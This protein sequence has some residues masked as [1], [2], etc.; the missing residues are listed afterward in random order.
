M[1]RSRSLAR[2][3]SAVA[4]L[5][6]LLSL[7]GAASPAVAQHPYRILVTNDDGFR[8]PG[9]AALVTA[10]APLG[11]LTIV[12][13]AE[14][15]SGI[16]QA[17][18][19]F[20]PIYADT[21][22]VAGHPATS[23]AATPASCV[24]VALAKLM[25]QPPDLVVSG[26][27]RGSNFGL[28]AYISGTVGAAREAAIEGIPAIAA[29]LDNA[30]HPNYGPAAEATARIAAIV[31][32]GGLPRRVFLNVNVPAGPAERLKGIRFARQSTQMGTERYDEQHTPY[33]RRLFW[34]F[35][36]QPEGAEPGTDV[37]AALDGYVSVTPL[38][39][40]EFDEKDFDALGAR[41]R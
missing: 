11:E 35:F 23:L 14:N 4:A 1:P 17:L 33:G 31:K 21:V 19:L 7:P 28:N 24:R 6:V 25:S 38:I 36:V 20:E 9:L 40:S 29:A 30:G 39:A 27:N 22:S 32:A 5:F 26:V 16:G 3:A 2:A 34:S 15:Q 41:F 13:P 10:L 37:A 18:T 12:A 8:A